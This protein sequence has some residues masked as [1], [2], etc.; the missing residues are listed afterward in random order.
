MGSAGIMLR[1]VQGE[2]VQ[3]SCIREPRPVIDATCAGPWLAGLLAGIL[4]RQNVY[5]SALLGTAIAACCVNRLG[6]TDGL[7]DF[8]QIKK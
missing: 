7:R 8:D 4:C 1:P 6:V 5:Q 2:W 3:V